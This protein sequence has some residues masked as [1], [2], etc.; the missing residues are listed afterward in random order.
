MAAK[1]RAS[2]NLLE[3]LLRACL[4]MRNVQFGATMHLTRVN[5]RIVGRCGNLKFRDSK[6]VCENYDSRLQLL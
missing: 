6:G 2:S 5:L 1:F 3:G 4:I